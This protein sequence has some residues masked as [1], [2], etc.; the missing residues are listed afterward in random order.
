MARTEQSRVTLTWSASMDSWQALRLALEHEA[1]AI[2]ATSGQVVVV[3]PDQ[4][5]GSIVTLV[6]KTR[7][8]KLTW[9]PEKDAVKWEAPDEYGFD[10]IPEV[11]AP[12]A[13]SLMRRVRR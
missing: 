3:A 4:E 13:R 6:S 2:F 9:V 1:E 8:L 7:S 5:S 11:I 10:P 12:L